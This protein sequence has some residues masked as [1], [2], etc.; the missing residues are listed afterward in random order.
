MTPTF[1]ITRQEP[2]AGG[3]VTG[4]DL[5]GLDDATFAA[6]HAAF[7]EHHVL[8][9][10]DQHLTPEQQLE[11]AARWGTIS[12][13]PYVP[14][15]E[16]YP[17]IMEIFQV[18][19]ITETWHADTTQVASPPKITMLLAR[20]L[21]ENGGDTMFAN[22]HLAWDGLSDGLRAAL[23]DLRAVHYGTELAQQSGVD[24]SVVTHAHPVGIHHPETGRRTLY[25]NADYVRHFE[26]WTPEESRPVLEYL[27]ARAE[28]P[29]YQYR[30]RW[31]VGDLVMWDNR[32]VQHRVVHD[33]GDAR[34]YLHRVT[35]EGD[36]LG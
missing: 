4:L 24:A 21:P 30:H 35:L 25:V 32:S 5:A 15:L 16:G 14:P 12:H 2:A 23:S 6:V 7:L 13:H 9:F 3:V 18:T 34:R 1:E 28:R 31:Q 33:Y 17:G 22:M 20:E 11:F 8:A 36:P 19:G 27:F 26:G 10:R 29:E